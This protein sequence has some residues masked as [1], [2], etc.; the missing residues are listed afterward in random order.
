MCFNFIFG[1]YVYMYKVY[2]LKVF[3]INYNIYIFKVDF[4]V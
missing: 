2:L 3:K 1:I 4:G